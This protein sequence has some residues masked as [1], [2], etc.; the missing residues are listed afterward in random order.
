MPWNIS[1]TYKLDGKA[2]TQKELAGADGKLE[3]HIAITENDKCTT[4]FYDS[5]ALQAAFTLDTDKC[6]NIVADGATVANVGSD[7]QISY[8]V[9]PGK[10]LDADIIADVMDF[11]MD[12][13]AINGVKLKLNMDIDDAELMDKIKQI[14]D[15]TKELND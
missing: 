9:L 7:K 11:E 5:Y 3:V 8:T 2:V 13:A 15:A 12:A 10:G 1:I 6:E 4:N 14:Q